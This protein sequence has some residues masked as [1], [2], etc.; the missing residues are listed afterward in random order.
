MSES[1]SMTD[2][3]S[4]SDDLPSMT[5]A[6]SMTDAQNAGRGL[7]PNRTA[8]RALM[9]GVIA[10]GVAGPAI[11]GGVLNV[12]H[13]LPQGANQNQIQPAFFCGYYGCYVYCGPYYCYNPRK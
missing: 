8:R 6:S 1:S 9:A 4:M 5:E 2:L 7:T 3:S 12:P 11:A 13:S 10:A